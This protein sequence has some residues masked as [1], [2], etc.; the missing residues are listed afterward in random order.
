MQS[1]LHTHLRHLKSL[2]GVPIFQISE[3]PIGPR[4]KRIEITVGWRFSD[5]EP[6]DHEFGVEFRKNS[7]TAGFDI[8]IARRPQLWR[9]WFGRKPH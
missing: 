4:S 7:T 2:F 3:H 6:D 1:S 9:R 5:P 8:R